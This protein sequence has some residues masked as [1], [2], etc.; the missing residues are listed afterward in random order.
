MVPVKVLKKGRCEEGMSE[1]VTDFD[2]SWGNVVVPGDSL[3]VDGVSESPELG[4]LVGP[5]VGPF[6]GPEVDHLLMVLKARWKSTV[7]PVHWFRKR[8]KNRHSLLLWLDVLQGIKNSAVGIHRICM[9][10]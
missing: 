6:V 9:S 1:G 2:G 5:G 4:P 7:I 8:G 3:E 10:V